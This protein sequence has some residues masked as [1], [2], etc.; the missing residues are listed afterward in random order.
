MALTKLHPQGWPRPR[1]H[2]HGWAGSGRLVVLGGQVGSDA[3]GRFAEG[4]VAQARLA[5]S[6]VLAVLAEA[7]GGAP[8]I[9]RMTWFVLSLRDYQANLPALGDAWREVMGP[10]FPAMT[11]VQVARLVEPEALLEIEATAILADA[12]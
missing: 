11:F 9:A 7:G 8:D 5:L 2:T 12:P 1:G 4:F 6:N 10:H 3:E